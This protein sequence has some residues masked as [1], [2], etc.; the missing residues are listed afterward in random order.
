MRDQSGRISIHHV[1][2]VE[3]VLKDMES[4]GIILPSDSPWAAPEEE[5]LVLQILRGL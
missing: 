4:N 2:E 3:K 5:G 1:D